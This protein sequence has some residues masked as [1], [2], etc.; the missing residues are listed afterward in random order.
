LSATV[1][2]TAGALSKPGLAMF[3]T[4]VITATTAVEALMNVGGSFQL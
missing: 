3:N 1:T 2:T 4:Q